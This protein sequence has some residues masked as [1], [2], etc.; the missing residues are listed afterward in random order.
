MEGCDEMKNFIV[1]FGKK[2]QET[3]IDFGDIQLVSN[4]VKGADCE[5]QLSDKESKLMRFFINNHK[6][7]IPDES[8]AIG[9]WGGGS[10]DELE[11]Y[12]GFLRQKLEYIR[13]EI[14]IF[15]INGLGYKICTAE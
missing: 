9:A 6:T 11:A 14:K 13:S 10:P 4:K 2:Y 7:V 8:V 1:R 5:V 15:K 12:V 3:P